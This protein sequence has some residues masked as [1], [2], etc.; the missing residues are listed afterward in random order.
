M[1][2]MECSIFPVRKIVHTEVECVFLE[3]SITRKDYFLPNASR[4]LEPLLIDAAIG[5][6]RLPCDHM[7]ANGFFGD[8]FPYSLYSVWGDARCNSARFAHAEPRFTVRT[9]SSRIASS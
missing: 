9:C 6:N 2:E 8:I 3:C 7:A 1:H 4:S 5:F